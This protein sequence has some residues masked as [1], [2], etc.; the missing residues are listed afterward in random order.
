MSKPSLRNP[1]PWAF[2]IF[3]VACLLVGFLFWRGAPEAVKLAGSLVGILVATFG[4]KSA[5]GVK[6]PKNR[7]ASKAIA[8]VAKLAAAPPAAADPTRA[9]RRTTWL[10]CG[11]ERLVAPRIRRAGDAREAANPACETAFRRQGA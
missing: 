10:P 4:A 11:R 2:A 1:G 5:L 9:P 3:A 6:L 8:E 7:D